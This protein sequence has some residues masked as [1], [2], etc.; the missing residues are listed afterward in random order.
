MEGVIQRLQ[1]RGSYR[2]SNGGGHTEAPMEGVIQRL[3]WRGSYRGSNGGGHASI[4]EDCQ[5]RQ[6]MQGNEASG[7][8]KQVGCVVT[9]NLREDGESR[10]RRVP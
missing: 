10:E 1:W 4:A 3:Q 7:E 9:H 8:H 6:T 5:R 2:G